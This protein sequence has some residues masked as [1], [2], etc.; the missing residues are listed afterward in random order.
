M[1][2]EKQFRERARAELLQIASQLRSIAAD[3]EIYR[4]FEREIIEPNPQLQAR[5]AFLDMLRGCYADGM[6]THALR[7]LEPPAGEPSLPHILEQLTEYPEL[8]HDRITQREFADDRGALERAAA[9]LHSLPA[10]R[11]CHHERTIP[12]L[13]STHRTLDDAIDLLLSTAKTYCWIITD[14]YLD[15]DV[16]DAEDALAV[17]QFAWAETAQVR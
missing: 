13:A 12:A 2:T 8:L 1:L 10:S 4:R 7:L 5:S 9:R 11:C 6:T 14:S 17:F 3:R 16:N 15:L